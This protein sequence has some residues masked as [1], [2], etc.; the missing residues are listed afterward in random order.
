MKR[1]TTL[2]T[3]LLLGFG[4]MAQHLFMPLEFQQA[5][6]KG[7]RSTDGRPGPNYWINHSDYNI[8]AD[9]DPQTGLLKGQETITYYNNSPDTLKK[10][11]FRLYQ[12]YFKKGAQRDFPAN[13][14]DINDGVIIKS[15]KINGQEYD[16]KAYHIYFTIMT[17]PLKKPIPPHSTSTVEIEWETQITLNRPIRYGKYGDRTFFVGYWYP[18]IAVYDDIFG[19][20]SRVFTGYQ[21]YYND[22]NNFHVE[23]T[24][25]YPNVVWGAGILLNADKIFSKKIYKR[26]IQAKNSDEIVHIITAADLEKG[27]VFRQKQGKITWVF[28]AKKIP[29]FAFATSDHYLWDGSGLKMPDGRRVFISAAYD[30]QHKEFAGKALLAR[31]IIENFSYKTLKVPF[32]YPKMTVFNGGGAMEYPMMVNEAN[33]PDSCADAYVTAHEIGHTYFPFFTG[34]N[35]TFYPFMDEGIINFIPRFTARDIYPDK[36][37]DIFRSMVKRYASVAGSFADLPVMAS[38]AVVYQQAY[39]HVAYNRPAFAYWQLTK[40]VGDSAFFAAL[41]EYAN[42]WAYR[43]PY[44]FDLFYTFNDVLGQDLSWFWKPYFFDFAYPDIGIKSAD[45][46]DGKLIVK[47]INT[48]GLPVYVKLTFY[49]PDGTQKAIERKMDVWKNTDQITITADIPQKP[50]NI[51]L[52]DLLGADKNPQD[53]TWK[54]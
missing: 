21:E 11:V 51:V 54:M 8:K 44:P 24:L 38:A 37:Q 31:K 1:L 14:K 41:R 46:K 32:P 47:V 29:E 17:V 42:R 39:R 3:G 43:H 7:T 36:C 30:P 52:D 45:Y 20:D 23:L 26:I 6:Q 4:L 19:W 16:A 53:N 5:Y 40:Y 2:L 13:P 27:N 35:E 50:V 48:G 28:E 15:V 9:F 22:H 33:F 49:L 10:L 12:N 34:A 18:E 25:P